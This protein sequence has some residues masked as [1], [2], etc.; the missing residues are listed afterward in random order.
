[1][2]E[3]PVLDLHGLSMALI[4]EKGLEASK[5]YFFP[6]DY[7][8]NNDYGAYLMAGLVAGEIVRVCGRH[9][10]PGYRFLASCV[11]AGFGE[12]ELPERI[13]LPVKPAVY[14]NVAPPSEPEKLL[15]D[16]EDLGLAAD[17]ASV[18]DMIIR[19]ARFFPTNVY[20]D[21]YEDV[22]GHEWYA[23]TVECAYQNGIIREELAPE[24]RFY[25]ERPVTLEEFLVFAMN[26]YQSRKRFPQ[27]QPCP[28]DGGCR[29]FA[30]PFVRAACS[31]GIIP[32]DGTARLDQVITRGEAV[33]MCRRMKI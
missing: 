7:T 22:V 26:G 27:E 29:E 3:T 10:D 30:R 11:T 32:P 15:S 33:D 12:W 23:G 16:V 18:L 5:P 19:T 25:P 14:E 31:V 4:K 17:R 8:H 1:M 28:Y 13:M 20:N 21:M 24:G 2:T 6:N 9:Q